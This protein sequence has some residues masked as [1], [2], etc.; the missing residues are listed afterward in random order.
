MYNWWQRRQRR[1]FGKDAI[2]VCACGCGQQL[3]WKPYYSWHGWPRLLNH[4][5]TKKTRYEQGKGNRGKA[6][7]LTGL[8]KDT[9]PSVMAISLTLKGRRAAA[10]PYLAIAGA[11]HTETSRAKRIRRDRGRKGSAWLFWSI[12]L[13]LVAIGAIWA[14]WQV[15]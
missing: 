3:Q 15:G 5:G 12:F 10:Y 2:V 14:V 11:K 7:W 6:S 4:H 9:H 1:L 8:T 13:S